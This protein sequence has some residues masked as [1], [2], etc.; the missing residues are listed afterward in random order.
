MAGYDKEQFDAE[1]KRQ[2]QALIVAMNRAAM[3]TA[4]EF[5]VPMMNALA[6]ALVA[7]QAEMLSKVAAG[8]TR[9]LLRDAMERGLNRQIKKAEQGATLAEVIVLGGSTQ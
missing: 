3:E 1:Q 2:T 7:L 6:G 9:K 8:R 4:K 5:D